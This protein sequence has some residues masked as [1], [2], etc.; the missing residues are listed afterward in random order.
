MDSL[1][2]AASEIGLIASDATT[3]SARSLTDS[4]M[5]M[6]GYARVNTP[7]TSTSDEWRAVYA[8]F[9]SLASGF[10]SSRQGRT[11]RHGKPGPS[12]AV[13]NHRDLQV[14]LSG[15]FARMIPFS[16]PSFT[17]NSTVKWSGM[18]ATN[19]SFTVRSI[20]SSCSSDSD[21]DRAAFA[22]ASPGFGDA[23]VSPAECPRGRPPPAT[24]PRPRRGP[25]AISPPC[26]LYPA[27]GAPTANMTNR[28][29][30]HT[31]LIKPLL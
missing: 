2:K 5:V 18:E 15:P 22:A 25:P 29:Y 6:L 27:I 11:N 28:R 7:P 1:T 19:R 16:P 24:Q 30:V 14:H 31:P 21:S 13:P 12:P 9:R 17:P 23:K 10:R 26:H 3:R 8:E 4:V 20:G